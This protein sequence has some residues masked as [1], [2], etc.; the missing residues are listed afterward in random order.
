MR[1]A[2]AT[3]VALAALYGSFLLISYAGRPG[4]FAGAEHARLEVSPNTQS[5]AE[6]PQYGGTLNVGHV[7]I[8][9]PALSWDPADW[10]WKQNMDTG[11]YIEQL[12]AADLLILAMGFVGP[13]T[14]QLVAQVEVSTDGR[15]NIVTDDYRTEARGVYAAG[16]ARRGQ[17]LVVWAL[18]EGR[19]A[20]RQMDADLREGPSPLATRGADRH[21]GG[22]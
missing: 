6:V 14:D 12:F 22:R 21:F 5:M 11:M 18:M 19:E 10:N 17:S 9:I 20:A 13:S 7:A 4:G 16:D 2:L 15:G 8:S 1:S 3:A